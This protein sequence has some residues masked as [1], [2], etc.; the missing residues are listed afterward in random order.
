MAIEMGIPT[1]EE[2]EILDNVIRAGVQSLSATE[3]PNTT[4]NE[5][6]SSS[7][8][9]VVSENTTPSSVDAQGDTSTTDSK[10]DATT[11]TATSTS[12]D[13]ESQTDLGNSGSE[14][15]EDDEEETAEEQLGES[16]ESGETSDD[17]QQTVVEQLYVRKNSLIYALVADGELYGYANT[18]DSA[19]K[20]S[21]NLAR[22]YM[23]SVYEHNYTLDH[24]EFSL[25]VYT[26]Y[27]WWFITR[28]CK[29]VTYTWV[30]IM[31]NRLKTASQ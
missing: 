5:T 18:S 21:E 2:L 29:E 13:V 31:E 4:V 27:K 7:D 12:T 16:S 14:D 17:C 30:P 11:A 24:G 25:T 8:T 22:Y 9:A 6:A 15:E 10:D 1:R 19:R 26:Q 3:T 28:Y 23:S 20:I